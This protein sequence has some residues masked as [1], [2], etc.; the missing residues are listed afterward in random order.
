MSFTS[1][2][3]AGPRAS[4]PSRD[5]RSSLFPRPAPPPA[6]SG[7]APRPARPR[8]HKPGPA[9]APPLTHRR[10]QTRRGHRRGRAFL[11]FTL[12]LCGCYTRL[13]TGTTSAAIPSPMHPFIHS[14]SH[15]FIVLSLHP[16]F[17]PQLVSAPG[18][19]KALALGS[20][21][22]QKMRHGL[23]SHQ[24]PVVTGTITHAVLS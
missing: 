5:P 22:P 11:F 1:V 21:D 7:P 6:Y 16:S 13:G 10:L 15:P 12:W 20:G 3:A 17:L 9:P 4:A 14:L 2:G 8:P 18:S 23:Y 24:V 19:R